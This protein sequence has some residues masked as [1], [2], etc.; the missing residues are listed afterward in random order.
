VPPPRHWTNGHTDVVVTMTTLPQQLRSD[1][2]PPTLKKSGSSI[3]RSPVEDLVLRFYDRL[4]NRWDDGAVDDTLAPDISFRGSLGHRSSG[5]AGWRTYRDQIRSSSPDF[6]NEVVELI[7]SEPRA[8]ARLQFSGT[9]DGPLLGISPT[10][11]KFTYSGA[12]F[13]TAAYGLIADIWVIGDLDDLRRQ[14]S[15]QD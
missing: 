2:K 1:E 7:I 11:R 15:Q 12:G 4:W 13:F 5:R 3:V 14:L 8:A 6:H 9:H 10:G